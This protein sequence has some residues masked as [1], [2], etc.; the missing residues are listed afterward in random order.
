MLQ[1]MQ[2]N[3]D[4][5]SVETVTKDLCSKARRERRLQGFHQKM[6]DLGLREKLTGGDD[7]SDYEEE[8]PEDDDEYDPEIRKEEVEDLLES[9]R[10]MPDTRPIIQ[11][12][13]DNESEEEEDID[14]EE[15]KAT[16]KSYRLFV[17]CFRGKRYLNAVLTPTSS[18]KRLLVHGAREAKHRA[19]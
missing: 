6:I 9:D 2:T 10:R 1:I 5:K 8:D 17:N 19:L 15:T 16:L 4:G 7:D 12:P 18:V 13:T 3:F 14:E 11:D